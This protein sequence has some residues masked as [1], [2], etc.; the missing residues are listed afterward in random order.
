LILILFPQSSSPYHTSAILAT[1]LEAITLPLRKKT[2]LRPSLRE[3]EQGLVYSNRKGLGVSTVLPLFFD[4][5]LSDLTL[6]DMIPLTPCIKD[7]KEVVAQSLVWR[8]I[9]DVGR[10]RNVIEEWS[11]QQWDTSLTNSTLFKAQCPGEL[12]FPQFFSN[13]TKGMGKFS[14]MTGLH[15]SSS[16]G[17]SVQELH[18]GV[19]RINLKKLH[20][21]MSLGVEEEDLTESQHKLIEYAECYQD[22]MDF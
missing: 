22:D 21:F 19:S 20:R 17:N 9:Q 3:V 14:A 7:M 4:G 16:F 10:N 6:S 5:T 1:A 11:Q 2:G 8:G 12:P 18:S 15:S 13:S